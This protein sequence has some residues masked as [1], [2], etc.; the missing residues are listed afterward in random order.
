MKY[1]SRVWYGGT[2][3]VRR[4]HSGPQPRDILQQN[5]TT[6]SWNPF[7]VLDFGTTRVKLKQSAL[8]ANLHMNKVALKNEPVTNGPKRANGPVKIN[9]QT[10]QTDLLQPRS[11]LECTIIKQKDKRIN[12]NKGI[13]RSKLNWMQYRLASIYLV[14]PPTQAGPLL[15][16]M[17]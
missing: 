12:A 11:K 1:S 6:K 5:K 7:L 4:C 14:L 16:L 15:H 2:N 9:V 3:N 10:W 13:T 17:L 8:S